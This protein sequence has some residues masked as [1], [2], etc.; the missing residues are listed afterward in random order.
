MGAL[1]VLAVKKSRDAIELYYAHNTDSF[2]SVP[3]DRVILHYG[4]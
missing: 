1:G 3:Y 4:S 2:V